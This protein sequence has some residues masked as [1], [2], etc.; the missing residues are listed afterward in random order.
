M[1]FEF[2]SIFDSDFK[3][4]LIHEI[5]VFFVRIK[6]SQNLGIFRYDIILF[7]KM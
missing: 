2:K 1:P 5:N 4:F 3:M 6:N 7:L